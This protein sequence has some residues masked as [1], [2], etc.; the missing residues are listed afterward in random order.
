MRRSASEVIRNLKRRIARLEKKARASKPMFELKITKEEKIWV[1]GFPGYENQNWEDMMEKDIH[2]FEDLLKALDR[3]GKLYSWAEWMPKYPKQPK[4][5][6][7]S[8]HG[9]SWVTSYEEQDHRTGASITY[10]LSFN[11]ARDIELDKD[12]IKM[13]EKALHMR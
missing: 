8:I 6:G 13:I 5:D 9:S 11:P 2:T 12:Q 7:N 10:T 1:N 4:I 3:I